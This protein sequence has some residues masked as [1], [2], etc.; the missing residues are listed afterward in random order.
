MKESTEKKLVEF[1]KNKVDKLDERE[2]FVVENE[3]DKRI[4]RILKEFDEKVNQKFRE[5]FT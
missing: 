3:I 1:L 4:K 2:R 5:L